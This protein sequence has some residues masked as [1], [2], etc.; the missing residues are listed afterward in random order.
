MSTVSA[1]I[2][3]HCKQDCSNKPRAKDA[4]GQYAC[5]TCLDRLAAQPAA[6][7]VAAK[8]VSAASPAK[9]A[10]PA[11]PAIGDGFDEPPIDFTTPA[12]AGPTAA[13]IP[14]GGCGSPVQPGS[15]I[16]LGCGFNLKTGKRR[17]TKVS[18]QLV[19]G[20]EVADA[21]TKD[22]PLMWVVGGAVGACLVAAAWVA[23]IYFGQFELSR[24]S[25][26][27][28]RVMTI[29]VG[30][31]AGAGV[32]LIARDRAG[33]V[34]GMLAVFIALGAVVAAKYT[35]QAL[36]IDDKV[37]DVK[38]M[39]SADDVTDDLAITLLA[40]DYAHRYEQSG[41]WKIEWPPGVTTDT[42]VGKAQFPKKL[43]DEAVAA[44]NSWSDAR[45]QEFK[46]AQAER[47]SKALEESVQNLKD[48]Q[49]KRS[50]GLW[51]VFPLLFAISLSYGA[52]SGGKR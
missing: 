22:N 46:T 17:K 23:I 3:V 47:H 40:R 42:A 41:G 21:L 37:G 5:K 14:C 44:W 12:E 34:T 25:V 13:F 4:T 10:Q 30:A 27:I 8:A 52:G 39:M 7:P 1:K 26:N 50:F 36:L 38:S 9:V 11:A 15:A 48:N 19:T 31:G 43:W 20:E 16:C 51:D 49:F 45:R 6:A 32:G 18:K 2:C 35:S 33:V 28:G 24:T 29:F